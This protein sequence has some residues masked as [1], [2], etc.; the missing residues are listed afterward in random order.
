MITVKANWQPTKMLAEDLAKM[1]KDVDVIIESEAKMIETGAKINIRTKDIYDTGMLY[2]SVVARKAG[3]MRWIIGTQ[4]FYA[5]FQEKGV[6]RKVTEAPPKKR[7]KPMSK[8]S[9]DIYRL[10]PR[11]YLIPAFEQGMDNIRKILKRLT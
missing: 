1:K 8:L 10:K 3:V 2:S 7:K 6:K 5:I 11:P 9:D 4:V